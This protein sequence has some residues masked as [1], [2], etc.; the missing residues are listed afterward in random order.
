MAKAKSSARTSLISEKK[1]VRTLLLIVGSLSLGLLSACSNVKTEVVQGKMEASSQ[2]TR[3]YVGHASRN[4][5]WS[6]E[7]QSQ[8]N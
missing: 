8:N 7:R 2:L 1:P 6:I 4:S 3:Q 5:L